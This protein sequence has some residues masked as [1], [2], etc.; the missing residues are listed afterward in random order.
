M[1][2]DDEYGFPIPPGV[3][4]DD[5]S[6]ATSPGVVATTAKWSSLVS[7]GVADGVTTG[8]VTLTTGPGMTVSLPALECNVAG[9]HYVNP[10]PKTF[11]VSTAGTSD[12][13][14]R[15][16]ARLVR[17]GTSQRVTAEYVA[18]VAGQAVPRAL[19][20]SD[21][22][23][24]VNLYTF[25]VPA[26]AGTPSAGSGSYQHS[27]RSRRQRGVPVGSDFPE[28]A[29][30][31]LGERFT[32]VRP[33]GI[34]TG[35]SQGRYVLEYVYRGSSIGWVL[36]PGQRL[37]RMTFA[38]DARRG[39]SLSD[40]STGNVRIGSRNSSANAAGD[41][42]V[43][44][45]PLPPVDGGGGFRLDVR[46][47]WLQ[48]GANVGEVGAMSVVDYPGGSDTG[49]D[50]FAVHGLTVAGN[51]D[52]AHDATYGEGYQSNYNWTWAI[53]GTDRCVNPARS[54][55]WSVDYGCPNGTH[56][57]IDGSLAL[58]SA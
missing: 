33:T 8:P 52:T 5:P 31:E 39:Y 57:L 13:Y 11:T 12:R 21:S 4:A 16:V 44:M 23:Y 41:A 54:H 27:W 51:R 2:A 32:L 45:A 22:V 6:Y 15:I 42:L 30:L 35:T 56:A 55:A 29:D 34:V 58:Y 18:G 49:Y 48:V 14:D 1:S 26:N 40:S 36:T 43:N 20:R 37:F 9:V 38:D 17:T 50:R 47:R 7:Y 3:A 28:W 25:T 24:E 46:A 10:T 53:N 19:T